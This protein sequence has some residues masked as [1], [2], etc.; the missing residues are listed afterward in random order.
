MKTFFCASCLGEAAVWVPKAIM[1]LVIFKLTSYDT[2]SLFI[3]LQFKLF[4][5]SGDG[6]Y[7]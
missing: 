2:L 5:F 6:R 1:V 3:A 7:I 4:C